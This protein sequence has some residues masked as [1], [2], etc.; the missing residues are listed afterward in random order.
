MELIIILEQTAIFFC[1][2]KGVL[3]QGESQSQWTQ[4]RLARM[5]QSKS[6]DCSYVSLMTAVVYRRPAKKKSLVM[7]PE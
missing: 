4:H 2:C 1:F 7:D 6:A 5:L 3:L